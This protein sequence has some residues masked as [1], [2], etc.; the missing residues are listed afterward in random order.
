MD[1][2][3][4]EMELAGISRVD[5]GLTRPLP[6]GAVAIPGVIEMVGEGTDA[7]LEWAWYGP[8][9]S[10]V[11]QPSVVDET[12][13][14]L[15][16][17]IRLERASDGRTLEF[18]RRWGV[19][20]LCKDHGEP[21]TH[22]P[23][24][25]ESGVE[26][27]DTWRRVSRRARTILAIAAALHQKKLPDPLLWDEWP[28][29][30][31]VHYLGHMG[32]G[33]APPGTEARVERKLPTITTARQGLARLTQEWLDVGGVTPRLAW[34][35]RGPEVTLGEQDMFSVLAVQLTFVVC[36]SAGLA[37]CTSCGHPYFTERRPRRDRRN[38]CLD[39]QETGAPE[40]DRSRDYRNRRRNQ[41]SG[42]RE[43][44]L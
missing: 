31:A 14:L 24:C 37:I 33:Q 5:G 7:R 12:T 32:E 4:K 28:E 39:C 2:L 25:Q 16:E 18:A 36:G 1:D 17:F 29:M 3:Q 26:P 42:D 30:W 13:G 10:G 44:D 11:D 8:E 22:H 9:Q 41:N 43:E 21:A 40:R 38:Y 35:R 23:P 6:L 19:L 27:L 34:G 20:R 15:D